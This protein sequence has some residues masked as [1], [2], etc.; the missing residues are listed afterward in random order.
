MEAQE[1]SQ[2]PPPSSPA[3]AYVRRSAMMHPA[4]PISPQTWKKKHQQSLCASYRA[5][6]KRSWKIDG[7]GYLQQPCLVSVYDY[8]VKEDGERVCCINGH[9]VGPDTEEK[10]LPLKCKSIAELIDSFPT[11]FFDTKC[12]WSRRVGWVDVEG[13]NGEIAEFCLRLLNCETQTAFNMLVDPAQYSMALDLDADNGSSVF[14][15][16]LKSKLTKEASNLSAEE[17]DIPLYELTDMIEDE[18]MSYLCRVDEGRDKSL[19]ITLQGTMEDDI[20]DPIREEIGEKLSKFGQHDGVYLLRRLMRASSDSLWAVCNYV[21]C[22]F[23][24]LERDVRKKPGSHKHLT[25]DG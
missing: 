7:S 5:R 1:G 15:S 6:D 3:F 17:S 24:Q 14:I 23:Q 2:L 8:G 19:L 12:T 20:F 9:E 4:T 13:S 16:A 22:N 18:T 10:P 21:D 25:Q 11:G